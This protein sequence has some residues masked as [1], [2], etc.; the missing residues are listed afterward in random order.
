MTEEI[1][2]HSAIKNSNKKVNMQWMSNG[3]ALGGRECIWI[4]YQRCFLMP[5]S[6][7]LCYDIL[8]Q[9]LGVKVFD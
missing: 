4:Y 3:V 1:C 5:L 6:M 2:M 7:E 8:F 9:Q